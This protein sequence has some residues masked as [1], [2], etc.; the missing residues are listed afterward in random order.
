M[1]SLHEGMAAVSHPR[2]KVESIQPDA[3]P[4]RAHTR[5]VSSGPEDARA[6]Q[7]CGKGK[8]RIERE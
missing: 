5:G 8:R 1:D 6:L 7:L 4:P 3:S 2:A